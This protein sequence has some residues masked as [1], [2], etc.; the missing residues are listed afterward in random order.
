MAED[1]PFCTGSSK[2]SMFEEAV[3]GVKLPAL[4]SSPTVSGRILLANLFHRYK[5]EISAELF[6]SLGAFKEVKGEAK[7]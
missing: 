7:F 3:Y 5:A 6:P 1:R 4:R 2:L